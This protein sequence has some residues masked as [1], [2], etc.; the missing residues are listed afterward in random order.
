MGRRDV[1]TGAFA[2]E[3]GCVLSIVAEQYARDE[4]RERRGEVEACKEK[5]VTGFDTNDGPDLVEKFGSEVY[6]RALTELAAEGRVCCYPSPRFVAESVLRIGAMVVGA[7]PFV[8]PFAA[9]LAV[10]A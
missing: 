4:W 1:I 6:D 9:A 8:A 5:L 10:L 2:A 7:S 3:L